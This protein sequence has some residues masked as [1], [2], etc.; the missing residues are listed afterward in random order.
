[1]TTIPPPR[2]ADIVR[3]NIRRRDL[4][5]FDPL[6]GIGS[7]G[8]RTSVPD[9]FGRPGD[10]LLLPD[11]ML[12]DSSYPVARRDLVSFELLRIRH[13][14]PFWCARCVNIRHK[15]LGTFGHLIL[16]APQ[17]RVVAMLEE[18]RLAS[19]P[20]RIIMLKARQWGGSTL[21]QMYFA[22]IQIVHKRNWHSL[23]CAHVLDTA[24][25]IRNMYDGM[26]RRYPPELWTEEVD[27]ALRACPD[28]RSTRA[29][30]GRDCTV[31]I[32]T[33][34]KPDSLRGHDIQMAH[35]SEVAFWCDSATRDPYDLIRTVCGSVP[36]MPLSAIV[37]EST[38]NGVGNFFHDMWLAAVQGRSAYRPVFVPWH[39]I[40]IYR[41]PDLSH[42]QAL[43]L[44]STM[45]AGELA[46]W[47]QGLSL[48]QI[49]WH[50]A[51]LGEYGGIT[52]AMQAE[53]PADPAEAFVNTGHPVFDPVRIES[54]RSDCREPLIIGTPVRQALVG[55]P[56]LRISGIDPD[57][58]GLLT[59][60]AYP[61]PDAVRG[62][63]IAVVDI[64]GRS[65]DSDWSVIAILK[66]RGHRNQ[67]EVV[68]QWRG[69]KDHD[70]VAW[71]AAA[72]ATYY[73]Q[74][75]LVIESN[76]LETAADNPSAYILG[77]LRDAYPNLYMRHDPE[78]GRPLYRPGFHTNRATKQ[79]IV[80]TLN[81][82]IRD[83]TY[84]E[85]DH[86]ALNEMTTYELSDNGTFAARHG[87]HDDI[88]ITRAIALYV[89]TLTPDP[90]RT[91]L[92]SF[93][94]PSS[95]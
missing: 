73:R 45:S 48:E 80:A 70:I 89:I 1:M 3:H 51:K 43:D 52:A 66:R 72:L 7:P 58:D 95:W 23:V 31:A 67:P 39:E 28:S 12:A 61:E 41:L 71:L 32:G 62:E 36:T 74:A 88:L 9:P 24:G 44:A 91:S 54:L 83:H 11:S 68:A 8:P 53:F 20:L 76:T 65:H 30:A 21:I 60:Y 16:N 85:R 42:A 6:S 81:A 92:S 69:H 29:I 22:W 46:L 64:G 50:R 77:T 35:L 87:H 33:S 14:F 63:Y 27:P 4:P 56:S 26:L 90:A 17:R 59:V 78:T 84:I 34:H 57:P 18:D 25:T 47:E 79:A 38:A 2:A 82:A 49:A 5:L 40:E 10:T 75:L 13:D 19:R 15:T 94:S 37:I 55:T 93:S 86:Q